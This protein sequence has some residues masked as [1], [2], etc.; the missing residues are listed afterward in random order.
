MFSGIIETIGNV[1]SI[2]DEAT[3]RHFTIESD[4]SYEAYVDQSIAHNGVCLTVTQVHQNTH[5][6]TAIQETLVKTNLKNLKPGDAV[7][8]ERAVLANSRMDGHFVQGHVDTVAWCT[9]IETVDGSWYFRFE[10]D[11]KWDKLMVPKGSICI[12]GVSLTLVDAHEGSFSV[13]IIPYTYEHTNF[14]TMTVNQLVNVE[15]DILG[16]YVI[17]YLEKLQGLKT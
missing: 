13:A 8:L 6:V 17:Q 3:N 1:V 10:T 11:R 9:K 5:R 2:E 12:N 15:F 16:K 4:I 14:S 7:N